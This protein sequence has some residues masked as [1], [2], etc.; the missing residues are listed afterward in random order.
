MGALESIAVLLIRVPDQSVEKLLVNFDALIE[1]SE[2]S[3]RAQ[4]AQMLEDAAASC[5]DPPRHDRLMRAAEAVATG[6]RC[7]RIRVPAIPVPGRHLDR[8]E[9]ECDVSHFMHQDPPE[10]PHL[11]VPHFFPGL[12]VRVGRDFT[13]AYERA[14]FTGELL[15]LLVC[16]REQDGYALTFLDRNVFLRDTVTGQHAMVENADNAWFQPVPTV[17]C[18]RELLQAIDM[19]MGET[20]DEDAESEAER[21]DVLGEDIERCGNWLEGEG[22]RGP[23][24]DC[25]SGPLAAKIFGRDHELAVWIPLLFAAIP[26]S[27]GD[28]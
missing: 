8:E 26:L 22:E 7:G 17:D 5:A 19:R 28:F 20:A 25:E 6:Q 4:A 12:V 15:S 10:L 1:G 16:E 9:D 11:P 21:L 3:V 2:V 14:L 23:A 18:L 27:L 13:D 24:P